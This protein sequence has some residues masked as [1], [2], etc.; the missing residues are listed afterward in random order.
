MCHRS[1]WYALHRYVNQLSKLRPVALWY[2]PILMVLSGI[3]MVIFDSRI[4]QKYIRKLRDM[5]RRRNEEPQIELGTD[6]H[7]QQPT[8]P[9]EPPKTLSI[10]PEETAV[11]AS[12]IN[13]QQAPRTN[14]QIDDQPIDGTPPPTDQEVKLPYSLRVGLMILGFF[15]ISF[16]VIM[17]IR[18]VVKD[19][20]TLFRFFANIYLAGIFPAK[21]DSC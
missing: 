5:F 8:S 3:A 7:S 6:S 15:L 18:G 14:I 10:D 20:P 11:S 4:I 2:F 1:C 12:G 13:S 21:S 17:V 19:L 9:E 16:I